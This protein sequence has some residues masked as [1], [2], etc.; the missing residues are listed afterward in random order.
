M[1]EAGL[2]SSGNL[3]GLGLNLVTCSYKSGEIL[4]NRL[5]A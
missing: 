1:Y 5:H 2:V 3:G 4:S